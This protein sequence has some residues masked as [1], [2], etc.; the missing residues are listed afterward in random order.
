VVD[1]K[2]SVLA[3]LLG[4]Y[5]LEPTSCFLAG[6][7]I[8]DDKVTGTVEGEVTGDVEDCLVLEGETVAPGRP[9]LL[10]ALADVVVLCD[11]AEV[12]DL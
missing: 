11:T 3:R 12:L 5:V 8:G 1:I 6:E 4:A 10:L 7:K 2:E 9:R